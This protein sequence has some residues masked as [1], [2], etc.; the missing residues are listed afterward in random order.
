MTA[1]VWLAWSVILLKGVCEQL[2]LMNKINVEILQ[3]SCS[4]SLLFSPEKKF[5]TFRGFA[6]Y[7]VSLY[8][9]LLHQIPRADYP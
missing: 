5:N 1:A 7:S 4:L 8:N 6:E 3:F 2:L 9:P